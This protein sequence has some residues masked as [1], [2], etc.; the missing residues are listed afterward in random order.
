M[1][2]GTLPLVALFVL[3]ACSQRPEPPARLI[4]GESTS[5]SHV[6]MFYGID[7]FGTQLLRGEE[8]PSAD[9][10]SAV[11]QRYYIGGTDGDLGSVRVAATE[12]TGCNESEF[13]LL[14]PP[15]APRHLFVAYKH[16]AE[17]VPL[18]RWPTARDAIAPRIEL[19]V[20]EVG[21]VGA[22]IFDQVWRF[23]MPQADGYRFIAVAHSARD[24]EEPAFGQPGDFDGIFLFKEE[25]GELSLLDH[26]T[27]VADA[28][29][30]WR[31]LPHPFAAAVDPADRRLE[32]FVYFGSYEAERVIGY[33][34]SGERLVE[35]T[36]GGCSL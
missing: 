21:G 16:P 28:A 1:S 30:D 18:A 19:V 26:R 23:K 25:A 14:L 34:V 33:D 13:A 20:R 10:Q 2:I 31:T 12:G 7:G 22:V 17:F 9:A 5:E 3:A 11:G 4:G 6:E 27:V 29:N 35:R 8:V 15:T 32:L 24:V 36:S